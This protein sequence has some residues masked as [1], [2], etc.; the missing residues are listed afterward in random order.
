MNEIEFYGEAIRRF[1]RF[2]SI[3]LLYSRFV[4][5]RNGEKK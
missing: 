3:I 4:N 2:N 5:I 1:S